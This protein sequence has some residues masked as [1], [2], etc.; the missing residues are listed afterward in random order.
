MTLNSCFRWRFDFRLLVFDLSCDTFWIF[1][2]E[3]SSVLIVD[4]VEG[5]SR[6]M[7]NGLSAVNHLVLY[8]RFILLV[9]CP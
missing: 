2:S 7:R 4:F 5:Y 8:N 1:V 6:M 9:D 3:D